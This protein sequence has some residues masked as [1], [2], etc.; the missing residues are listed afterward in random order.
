MLN[1]ISNW[2]MQDLY[3]TCVLTSQS[4][5]SVYHIGMYNNANMFIKYL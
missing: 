2:A 3:I 5:Y 4:K 1:N